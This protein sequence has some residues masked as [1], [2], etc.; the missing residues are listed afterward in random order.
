M[1]NTITMEQTNKLIPE[2]R[3][4][5]FVNDGEW[6][7]KAVSEVAYYENGKAHEQDIVING[8]YKVVNSKFISTDGE[9]VKY[10]N[11]ALCLANKDDTL[12]VLSDV[13]NGK[14]I[15][16]CFYVDK[17]NVYTVNQ[18]ICK[19]TPFEINGK[20]LY[21]LLNRNPYFLAFDDGVKQ[22]NLKN[23]DVLN[24]AIAL[25]KKTKDHKEQKKI[26]DCLTSLDEVIT[27]HTDKLE[28]LKTNK[29]G[30]LQN[31]FPQ[32]G[33]TVPN[34]RFPEFVNDEEWEEKQ[35]GKLIEIKGRI[36]YRGYTINDI[37]SKGKGAISMSP[38][39]IDNNNR[40]NF[41]KSTYISWEKYNES[42]EIMLEDGYTVLV[43]TGSSY[44]KV[45]YIK[46]L[47]EKTT[48]NPQL[49]VLKPKNI[50][51]YFLHLLIT[52][53]TIQIKIKETVVGGAIPTLSQD[54]ISKFE[55]Y[56]PKNPKEQQ[57][58]ADCLMAID[59]L[60]T[61]QTEKIDQL[62]AHKKGLMQG[63][64]PKID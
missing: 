42:P 29:K 54:S 60:I 33:Q 51:S 13:P 39:N 64:F 38:S 9:V 4:P 40:L 14:A 5:E 47:I 31:L 62:K 35:L 8:K 2:L 53:E 45:A 52:N 26:A 18:R 6:E 21:Y 24:C 3:F 1:S 61:A 19:L 50:D 30:L 16:K 12:M 56:I 28:A 15:A 25:P 41:D 63:L 34:Y 48:I 44:G 58:I 27:A 7:I 59:S 37:V 57:K 32:E 46:N 55:V 49:V 23:D 10:T 11:E 17:N 20:I 43:K 36:G 22:T